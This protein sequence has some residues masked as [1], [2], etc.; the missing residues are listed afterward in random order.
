[1]TV[2]LGLNYIDKYK[3]NSVTT[4][5]LFIPGKTKVTRKIKVIHRL[6]GAC[7]QLYQTLCNSSI[8]TGILEQVFSS[9]EDL[10]NPGIKPMSPA[11]RADSLPAEPL[12]K[13]LTSPAS[14]ELAGGLFTT[15]PDGKPLISLNAASNHFQTEVHIQTKRHL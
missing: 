13:S 2:N 11:L 5:Q 14:L 15:E 1:M 9:P 3:E 8:A 4:T 7:A 10:P 6:G 12:G